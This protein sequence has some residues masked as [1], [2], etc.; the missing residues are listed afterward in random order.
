MLHI[1]RQ[2][3]YIYQV[4]VFM[5]AIFKNKLLMQVMQSMSDGKAHSPT[6]LTAVYSENGMLQLGVM[7]QCYFFP[8]SQT[9][10]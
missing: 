4:D 2:K 6:R 9:D 5:S 3:L 7:L 8:E 1:H 10:T